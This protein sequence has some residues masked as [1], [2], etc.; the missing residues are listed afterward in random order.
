[1]KELTKTLEELEK[2]KG[3]SSKVELVSEYLKSVHFEELELKARFLSGQALPPGSPEPLN[4][5]WNLLIRALFEVQALEPGWEKIYRQFGDLGQTVFFLLK[6]KGWKENGPAVSLKE[7]AE[8]LQEIASIKGSDARKKKE[9]LLVKLLPRL[10][11]LE[12]KFLSRLIL[13][14]LRVGLKENLVMSAIAKAFSASLHLVRQANLLLSDIGLVALRAK[15]GKVEKTR[16]VLGR[17]FQ[18]MLAET[19][20]S[21]SELFSKGNREFLAEDKYDG[22]R[23]QLHF[24]SG[25]VWLFSRNL[26]EISHNFPEISECVKKF[27]QQI[28]LDG[29]IVAYKGVALPFITLQKRLHRIQSG[30]L[31]EE[32]PVYYFVFDLLY[33]EG[34]CLLKRSLRERRE[35]LSALSFP[36]P[37]RLAHQV[38]IRNAQEMEQAFKES[39]A[40]GNEGLVLKEPNSPYT[41]G[42]RGR[43][44]LKYKRELST[45][46]C[47]VVKVEWGHGKRAGLLSDFTFAVRGKGGKLLTIG[48]AFSGLS[49]DEIKKLTAWFKEHI[50]RDEE[51]GFQVEPKIIVEVAFNGIQKSSRH[52]SGFALRFPR[53]KGIREDKGIQEISTLEEVE[54]IFQ[55][56]GKE[57]S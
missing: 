34:E 33:L 44:W 39:R 47:V 14:D 19:A 5:G 23:A 12:I 13:G 57:W 42:K 52:E 18:F 56:G 16:L 54:R 48:K 27:S 24:S 21:S 49:E 46:D 29:E 40:R 51:W 26:E 35:L 38:V 53:I 20:P 8:T 30:R 3:T 17:P 45:L 41:P 25:H 50:V 43:Q 11:P 1:M 28:I 37:L 6:N 10:S 22:I 7:L 36:E 32:I 4:V 9:L 15:Q 2:M 55:E 31:K